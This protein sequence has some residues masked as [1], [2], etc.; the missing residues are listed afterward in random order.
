MI[1]VASLASC[2]PLTLLASSLLLAADTTPDSTY[3]LWGLGLAGVAVLLFIAEIF[4]P[5]G[6]LIG[7]ACVACVVGSVIFL[8]KHDPSWG[9]AGLAAYCVL[10][11]M[12]LL[13]GLKMWSHSPLAKRMILGAAEDTDEDPSSEAMADTDL[14]RLSRLE[15]LRSLI[16][17]EGRAVTQLRPIG[18]V[19]VDGRRIDALAEGPAIDPGTPIVIVDVI[20]NQLKVRAR[21]N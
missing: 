8:F 3:L 9:M 5:T 16:G 10:A 19:L 20:D 6:G 17:A 1:S 14:Q 11:P 13:F 18:F 21:D 12:A 15:A 7:V 2:T 4:V